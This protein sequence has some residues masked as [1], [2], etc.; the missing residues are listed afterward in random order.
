[1]LKIKN[2]TSTVLVKPEKFKFVTNNTLYKRQTLH[3]HV[4]V[5]CAIR[6]EKSIKR[7]I[8]G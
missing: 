6:N 8:T 4:K 2:G 3:L 7:D 5:C 1:M